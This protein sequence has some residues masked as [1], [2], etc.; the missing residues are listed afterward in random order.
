MV[1]G[2]KAPRPNAT[3]VASSVS[4]DISHGEIGSGLSGLHEDATRD[5]E[6]CGLPM[7]P[8]AE[9]DGRVTLECANR[10]RQAVPIPN[11]RPLRERARAWIARRGAQLHVQHERWEAEREEGTVDERVPRLVRASERRFADGQTAG[12]VREEAVRTP[13]MWAGVVRTEPG[14]LSSWHH[15]GDHES[16]IFVLSGRVQ[17]ECGPGGAKVFHARSG[18]YIYLPPREIHRE[19]N[20]GAE[21]SEIVVVRAGAGELVV[22]VTGPAE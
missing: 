22:N 14:R 15:H 20:D 2:E 3:A 4:E 8:I 1:R 19:G 6:I 18:D 5:C 11:Y 17:L 13:G 16:V 12:M 10:H 7:F 21:E 9:A